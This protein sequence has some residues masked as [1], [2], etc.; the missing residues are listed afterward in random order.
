M[1]PCG[2][3]LNFVMIILPMLLLALRVILMKFENHSLSDQGRD[4]FYVTYLDG[5]DC[6]K[7]LI[8]IDLDQAQEVCA[9]NSCLFPLCAGSNECDGSRQ[10]GWLA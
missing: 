1:S 5:V 3:T 4:L 2:D 10:R 6:I 9:R 8:W 7:L